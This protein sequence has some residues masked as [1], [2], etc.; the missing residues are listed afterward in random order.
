LNFYNVVECIANVF[1]ITSSNII[2]ELF[3]VKISN[4]K[5]FKLLSTCNL[6]YKMLSSQHIIQLMFVLTLNLHTKFKQ[7]Y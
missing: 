1:I 5:F 2:I 4:R 6:Y 7:M 3:S